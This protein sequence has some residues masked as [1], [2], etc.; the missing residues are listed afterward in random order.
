MGTKIVFGLPTE[1]EVGSDRQRTQV[2]DSPK[3]ER[4]A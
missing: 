4:E 1:K 2:F 3:Q